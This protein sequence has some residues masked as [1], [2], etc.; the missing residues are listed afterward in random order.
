MRISVILMGDSPAVVADFEKPSEALISSLQLQGGATPDFGA[1]L[2][3][4]FQQAKSQQ[5][6]S[7]TVDFVVLAANNGASITEADVQT[8]DENIGTE[9]PGQFKKF[10]GYSYSDTTLGSIS[11]MESA[12][13]SN[14]FSSSIPFASNTY[15]TLAADLKTDLVPSTSVVDA[16]DC[17]CPDG[18]VPDSEG[19][20]QDYDYTED[21]LA[22]KKKAENDTKAANNNIA[23]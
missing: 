20:C 17:V 8:I 6:K 16:V 14:G 1:A 12:L 23:K 13:N 9:L 21:D 15:A 5:S 10:Q 4:A 18:S 2:Q 7:S 3:E 19:K 22:A 11:S